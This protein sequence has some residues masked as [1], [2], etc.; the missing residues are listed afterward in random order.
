MAEKCLNSGLF[1]AIATIIPRRDERWAKPQIRERHNYLIQ[2][3]REI[4]PELSIPLV[5]M[6]DAFLNYPAEDGGLLSL[7]SEDLKHPNEKGYQFMA[8]M[9]FGQIEDYPF[10]PQNLRVKRRDFTINPPFEAARLGTENSGPQIQQVGLSAGRINLVLWSPN[11]KI[12]DPSIIK[13][14][15]IYR[16]WV[17]EPNSAFRFIAFVAGET[18]YIDDEIAPGRNYAYTV[19]TVRTD[20]IEG[21]SSNIVRDLP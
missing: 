13:G 15:K 5:E 21:P 12:T 19:S 17:E 1:P 10:P 9:W 8:E 4:A 7:L 20:Q 2:K 6:H 16:R 3:I 14:Y 18:R 11:R